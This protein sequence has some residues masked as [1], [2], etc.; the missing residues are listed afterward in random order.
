MTIFERAAAASMH[1]AAPVAVIAKDL[2]M[3]LSEFTPQLLLDLRN[4]WEL[5]G[6]YRKGRATEKFIVTDER[7]IFDL[8]DEISMMTGSEA[9]VGPVMITLFFA[10]RFN[11]EAKAVE[12]KVKI[13]CRYEQDEE[14]TGR[15]RD[16]REQF[17]GESAERLREILSFY[18]SEADK[19]ELIT[20]LQAKYETK[21]RAIRGRGRIARP[22]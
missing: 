2:M 20:M 21:H 19:T 14:H 4:G 8:A 15:N 9:F 12:Y 3:K 16:E 1:S 13:V 18:E 11:Y 7:V 6:T 17:D 10:E 22:C 5:C